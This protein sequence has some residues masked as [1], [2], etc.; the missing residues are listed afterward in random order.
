MSKSPYLFNDLLSL[1]VERRR[2][3]REIEKRF[4][5]LWRNPFWFLTSR[6]RSTYRNRYEL[7][8]QVKLLMELRDRSTTLVPGV[9]RLMDFAVV[10]FPKCGTSV[11]MRMLETLDNVKIERLDEAL[12]AP[13]FTS[14]ENLQ[15]LHEQRDSAGDSD[16][17]IVGHK[18]SSYAF[19]EYPL[20]RLFWYRVRMIICVRDPTRALVS[21]RNMH[22]VIAEK[23][24]PAG[25]FVNKSEES[26]RFYTEASLEEYYHAFARERLHYA[27]FIRRIVEIA[28]GTPVAIVAQSAMAVRMDEVVSTLAGF[29]GVHAPAERDQTQP[30]RGVGDTVSPAGLSE[31]SLAELARERDLLDALLIELR[32]TPNVTV[33]A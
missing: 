26:R 23:G 11:L 1:F 12:E 29:L 5:N 6:G 25:H 10:G 20:E 31:K 28:D 14:Q 9:P 8:A 33:V 3:Y 4:L 32:S 18:F 7:K 15:R 27:A 22:R 21:W 2:Q 24:T 13:Y 30:H 19:H 17:T 16:A